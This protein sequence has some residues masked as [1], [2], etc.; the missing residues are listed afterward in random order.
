MGESMRSR[1]RA[2]PFSFALLI[3]A[4][5][6][7]AQTRAQSV[8]IQFDLP[9]QP[10]S[11]SLGAVGRQFNINVLFD[12]A[13]VQ[14]RTAPALKLSATVDQTLAK[15][16]V[17]SG[18]GFRFVD[19]KTVAVGRIKKSNAA[20][21]KALQGRSSDAESKKAAG[22]ATPPPSQPPPRLAPA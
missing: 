22:T 1:F 15:L 3:I 10:L 7:A 12:P 14:G 11:E 6:M 13:V 4:T 16:L 5:S 17:G 9:E 21:V 2:D 18:L 20:G 19:E 8:P